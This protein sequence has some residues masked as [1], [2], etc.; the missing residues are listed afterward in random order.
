MKLNAIP[1]TAGAAEL[2]R[3]Q[4]D[5]YF[6][7]RALW[8]ADQAVLQGEVPVGAVLVRGGGIVGEGWNRPIA[9]CDPTA[10]AEIVALREAGHRLNN[11]RLPDT[12]LYATLEPCAMC[13]GAIL[14]A[15]VGRVVFGA[16]DP[17]AGAAG[18]VLSVLNTRQ[19]NHTVNITGGVLASVCA[20]RLQAFFAAR[21]RPAV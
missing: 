12:T 19:L 14:Q 15:R 17:K 9:S 10:H 11:Y 8:L 5:E 1:G 7:R 13:S 20:E 4:H 21:R 3:D 16:Y 6:M 2:T 18:S